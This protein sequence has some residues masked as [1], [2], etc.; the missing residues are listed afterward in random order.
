ML[1]QI[2]YLKLLIAK[3]EEQSRFREFLEREF[4][5]ADFPGLDSLEDPDVDYHFVEVAFNRVTD[6][7]E[8]AHLQAIPTSFHLTRKDVDRLREV[9]GTILDEHPDFQA[10]LAELTP[11]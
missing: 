11:K 6:P 10:L 1:S 4:P 2:E 3:L 7:E 8:R 9:A 5:D